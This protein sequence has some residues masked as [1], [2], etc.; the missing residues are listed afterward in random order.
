MTPHAKSRHDLILQSGRRQ[1]VLPATFDPMELLPKSLHRYADDARYL[2]STIIR[3]SARGQADA[4]GYVPLKAEFLRNVISERRGRDVIQSL[5]NAEGIHRRPY[6]VGVRS[7]AYRLDD[8]FKA[9]KH[10]RRPIENKRLLKNLERHAAICRVEAGARMKPVHHELARL[11]KSLQIDGTESKAVLTMLPP[12]S[13]PF[14]IQGVLVQ[15][16]VDRRFRL[17][18]GGYGRVANSITSLKREL[19]SA[20]R[21]AGQPIAGVDISCAQPCLLC[22]LIRVCRQNVTSYIGTHW[23]P[24]SAL[25]VVPFL[26]ALRLNVFPSAVW[27][28]ICSACLA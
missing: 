27:L 16:I 14:D 6:Q 13:N 11:Q 23:L 10:I 26:P 19:R 3:K 8:R 4:G 5:L 17:S 24:L 25:P 9:D 12:E 28:V 20:L 22:L 21:C 18:V 7:F 15:D 1:F 2:A